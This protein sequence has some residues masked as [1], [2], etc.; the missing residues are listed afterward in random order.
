MDSRARQQHSLFPYLPVP[1]LRC[2]RCFHAALQRVMRHVRFHC[3]ILPARSIYSVFGVP[4]LHY[5]GGGIGEVNGY[6]DAVGA[7]TES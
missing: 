1:R 6:A 5:Q 3:T 2:S 4:L 7:E